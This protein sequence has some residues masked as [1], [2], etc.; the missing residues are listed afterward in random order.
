[1][2][3]TTQAGTTTQPA[4]PAVV[5]AA[6]ATPSFSQ[7]DI[8]RARAEGVEQGTQTERSRVGAILGHQAASCS[9]LAMQCI[10]TGLTTEQA[11]AVLGA[12][13][14]PAA[15]APNNAFAAAMAAVPNPGVSGVEAATA[16]DSTEAALAASIVGLLG[17][18]LQ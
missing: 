2:S 9:P 7:A 14:A 3:E 16:P 4:P 5:H 8:E 11:T 1:M 18:T 12:A 13:P 15:A 17:N 6:A 10:N